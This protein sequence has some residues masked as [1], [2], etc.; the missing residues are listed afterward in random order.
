MGVS[1]FDEFYMVLLIV[2]ALLP[3]F[4]ANFKKELHK[5]CTG[6]NSTKKTTAVDAQRSNR[7]RLPGEDFMAGTDPRWATCPGRRSGQIEL[8]GSEGKH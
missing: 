2:R 1:P 4:R 7:Q 5:V 6:K 3:L 8:V